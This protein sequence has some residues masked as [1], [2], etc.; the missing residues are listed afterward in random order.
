M[1]EGRYKNAVPG[2]RTMYKAGEIDV[3]YHGS[4]NHRVKISEASMSFILLPGVDFTMNAGHHKREELLS[5]S[6]SPG[7]GYRLELR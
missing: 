1:V 3:Y 2:E 7:I 6:M 4:R 5:Q